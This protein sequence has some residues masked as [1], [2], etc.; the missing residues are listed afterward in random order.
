MVTDAAQAFG[1]KI[2][3]LF[4]KGPAYLDYPKSEPYEG[5]IMLTDRI[6]EVEQ[7]PLEQHVS[8]YHIGRYDEPITGKIEFIFKK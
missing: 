5:R 3:G 1:A 6:A 2:T 8:V 4:K 7:E